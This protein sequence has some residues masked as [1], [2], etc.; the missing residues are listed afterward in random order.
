MYQECLV[1][2]ISCFGAQATQIEL[3]VKKGEMK[4]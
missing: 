4:S 2:K 3:K 1:F